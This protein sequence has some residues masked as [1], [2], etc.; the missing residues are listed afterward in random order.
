MS[1]SG[2]YS[3]VDLMAL[4]VT[5]RSVAVEWLWKQVPGP[6]YGLYPLVM[7]MGARRIPRKLKKQ[8]KKGVYLRG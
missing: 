8:L 7:A 2:W 4:S 6:V 1:E 3:G 5:D